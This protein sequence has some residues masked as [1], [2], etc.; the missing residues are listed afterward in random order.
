MFSPQASIKGTSRLY[1]PVISLTITIEVN[2]VL[3]TPAK[4]PPMPTSTNAAGSMWAPGHP[5]V[6]EL[7]AGP[8]EH[9]ADQHRRAEHAAAAAGA[10]RQAGRHDLQARQGQAAATC[11]CAGRTASR[12]AW[13]ARAACR[14]RPT[15]PS[16]SRRSSPAGNARA[17]RPSSSPPTAGLMCRGIGIGLKNQSRSP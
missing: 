8:A 5:V 16:R 6:Q 13:S 9:A 10:D 2:G 4:K 1:E 11:P 17:S 3:E 15:A 14:S 7:A 12:P